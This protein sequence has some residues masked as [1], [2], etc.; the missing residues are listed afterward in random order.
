MRRD[1][2][3][4]GRRLMRT[5]GKSSKCGA[6]GE[7][8]DDRGSSDGESQDNDDG[9]GGGTARMAKTVTGTVQKWM[10]VGTTVMAGRRDETRQD[11]LRG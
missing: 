11:E 8:Q 1:S 3:E 2:G 10:G 4:D 9:S 5:D 6:C 7:S